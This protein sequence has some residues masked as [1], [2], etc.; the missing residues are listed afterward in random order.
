MEDFQLFDWL[1]TNPFSPNLQPRDALVALPGN[2]KFLKALRFLNLIDLLGCICNGFFERPHLVWK[3][4]TSSFDPF[5]FS[6]R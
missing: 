1:Y 2:F 4:K 6:N 3:G 5:F